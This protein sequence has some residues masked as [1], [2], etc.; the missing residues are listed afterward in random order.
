MSCLEGVGQLRTLTLQG[1]KIAVIPEEIIKLVNLEIFDLSQNKITMYV[2][3]HIIYIIIIYI[4][5]PF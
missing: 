3:S 1:N 2:I 4:K 5:K